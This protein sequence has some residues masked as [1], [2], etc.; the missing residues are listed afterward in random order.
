MKKKT[1]AIWTALTLAAS[2]SAG[3]T[4][5]YADVAQVGQRFAATPKDQAFEQLAPQEQSRALAAIEQ[6]FPAMRSSDVARLQS[7]EYTTTM[8]PPSGADGAGARGASMIFWCPSSGSNQTALATYAR[9]WKTTMS[10]GSNTL[11]C[12]A[13]DAASTTGWGFRHIKGKH[14]VK[15]EALDT[16]IGWD[17]TLDTHLERVLAHA[18]ATSTYKSSNQTY[19]ITVKSFIKYQKRTVAE[20]WAYVVVASGSGNV[21][22]SYPGAVSWY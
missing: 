3:A 10:A 7:G 21:I 9:T 14:Q 17:S 5:A 22:T 4:P 1:V 20:Y 11:R 6:Q 16:Y 12:G 15:F 19:M 13:A 18:G 8:A 2:L